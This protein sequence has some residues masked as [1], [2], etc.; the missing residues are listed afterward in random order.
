MTIRVFAS[1]FNDSPHETHSF[2]GPTVGAWIKANAPS[3]DPSRPT[4]DFSVAVNGLPLCRSLW[5]SHA[6]TD[7]DLIDVTVEP[8]GTELFFGGLFFAAVSMMTP[9]IPKA[10]ISSANKSGKDLDGVMIKG[11]KVKM[12]DTRPE[13]AGLRKIYPSFLKPM[14][15]YFTGLRTQKV[16]LCLDVGEGEFDILTS[17][18]F[19]GDTPVVSLGDDIS[20]KIYKP[21]QSLAADSRAAWWHDVTEIGAGSNG[22]SGLDM[23]VSTDITADYTAPVAT[24]TGY[25]VT[26]PSGSGSFPADWTAGMILRIEAPYAYTVTDGGAGR[27]IITGNA[28]AMLN[29]SPGD[30]IEV[31]GV[32]DGYYTVNSYTPYSPAVAPVV[33]TASTVTASDVPTRYDYNISPVTFKLGGG[34]I[35]NRLDDI[36][37]WL[38]ATTPTIWKSSGLAVASVPLA[39]SAS[40]NAYKIDVSSVSTTGSILLHPT[41]TAGNYVMSLEAGTYQ[42]S[43]YAS[44]AN[45]GTTLQ[46]GV[47]DGSAKSGATQAITSVRTRYT[48]TV[49]I[50]SATFGAVQI[51]PNRA[52]F[53][54]N[55]ITIDSP[56]I[57]KTAVTPFAR[58]TRVVTI[59]TAT[60]SLTG[61]VDAINAKIG[62]TGITASATGG[63]VKLAEYTDP[64][65]GNAITLTGSTS[66]IFGAAPV[67]VTGTAPVAGSPAVDASMTLNLESGAPAV[68]LELGTAY[69][70]IGPRGLRYRLSAAGTQ[71]ITV[72]RLTSSG[73]PDAGFPGFQ[74]MT[75]TNNVMS[76]DVSNLEG[77]WRGP[78]AGC[79]ENE[80]TQEIQYDVL[81]PKGLIWLGRKG[82]RFTMTSRHT[83]EWRDMALAGAWTSVTQSFDAK[84]L[85][86]VGKSFNI[87]LPYPM[88]P[89][90]RIKKEFVDMGGRTSEY[91]SDI[92][93]YGARTRL[94]GK[95]VYATST[96][97]V[98][99][100]RGGDRLSADAESQV[101]L[102]ATRKLPVR[103][104]GVWQPAQATRD[105]VPF[106]LYVLK[107]IGYTDADFDLAA[108]DA[109]D[110]VC[111]ARGDTYDQIHDSASTVQQ[112]IEDALAA[113]FAELTVVDGLLTPKRDQ[114]MVYKSLYTAD[115]MIAP[116][117][118]RFSSTKKDDYDGVDVEYMD[119]K[120]WQKDT[121]KCRLPGDLGNR[122]L[123]IT[124]NGVTDRKRAWRI[125]MRKRRDLKYRKKTY[126]WSTEAESFNSNYLDLAQVSGQTPGYA[127]SSYMT[128]YA[129]RLITSDS[130]LPWDEFTGPYYVSVRRLDGTNFGPIPVTKV[131][132]FQALMRDPLDFVPDFENPANDKFHML[133]GL[134]YAVQ[135]TDI[136]FRGSDEAE[137][138]GRQYDERVYLDDDSPLPAE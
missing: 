107:S 24:F 77:G 117:D 130:V 113:G 43:F 80:L 111:R 62:G 3:Y 13:V 69:A 137:M 92:V 124:V 112:V 16:D 127:T 132:D 46:A 86:A 40:G 95:T 115:S 18:I 22:S 89:E 28:L 71:S 105:I 120:K 134:G 10:N 55:S 36:Y 54:S 5:D 83:L 123:K 15:R 81:C 106:C 88:R 82:E 12:N 42:V 103:V 7:T 64:K 17:D 101:W 19:I 135:I 98:L 90:F 133:F 57:E 93:W 122:V 45:D 121:V 50:A 75:Q 51:Y 32:N 34:P 96:T 67:F 126:S 39:A 2:V 72:G 37:S 109:F 31:S 1:K 125:G 74:L 33:G 26:I 119:G 25:N 87:A 41:N 11:N 108:W 6:V 20:W 84:T 68:N 21:G 47:Y 128:G 29:P 85:N 138:E 73:A 38:G 78:F 66:D 100:V 131:N 53:A 63:R 30:A 23:T 9:K 97:I 61:L 94:T 70:A 136:K 104:G 118:I 114:P 110:A 49:V 44:S 129:N 65:S 79:P 14:H 59:D 52:G 116:L 60:T 35:L 99:T 48:F 76:L 102:K 27:D 8:K 58:G 91:V 4:Q 56:Q